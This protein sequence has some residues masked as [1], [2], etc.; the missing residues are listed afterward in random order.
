LA[1]TDVTKKWPFGRVGFGTLV[2]SVG[3]DGLYPSKQTG[4]LLIDHWLQLS[5]GGAMQPISV[6]ALAIA[7]LLSIGSA[8]QEQPLGDVA[9]A[10]RE[11]KAR[12]ESPSTAQP[13][14]ITN[15]ELPKSTTDVADGESRPATS[16]QNK[17]HARQQRSEQQTLSQQKAAQQWK[18]EILAQQ[19]KLTSLQAR[20]DHLNAAILAANGSTQY[21]FP[22]GRFQAHQLQRVADLQVDLDEQKRALSEMQEEARQAGMHTSVYDP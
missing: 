2:W 1:K 11:A 18:R 12:I 22:N 20:I 9:R 7:I 21:E 6:Q 15:A 5:T 17:N 4:L 19:R 16:Q 8:A 13:K 3:Y 14:V 10:S